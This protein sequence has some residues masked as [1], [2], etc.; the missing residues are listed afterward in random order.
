Y[1]ASKDGSRQKMSCQKSLQPV[2]KY[3]VWDSDRSPNELTQA[4]ILVMRK[5]GVAIVTPRASTTQLK[6]EQVELKASTQ[7]IREKTKTIL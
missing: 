5:S 3:R 6:S 1:I 7:L 4:T 2:Q